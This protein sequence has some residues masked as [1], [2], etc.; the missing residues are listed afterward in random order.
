MHVKVIGQ[1][2]KSWQSRPTRR[3]H[4]SICRHAS[5]SLPQTALST[6][7]SYTAELISVPPPIGHPKALHLPKAKQRRMLKRPCPAANP[8]EEREEVTEGCKKLCS[9]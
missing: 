4:Y 9:E 8:S 5:Q 2:L 6:Y 3:A 7:A 1:E